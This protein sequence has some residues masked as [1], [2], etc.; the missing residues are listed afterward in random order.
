MIGE[1]TIEGFAAVT[2]GPDLKLLAPGDSYRAAFSIAVREDDG[3]P[4]SE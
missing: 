2:A 3:S 4:G 1:R